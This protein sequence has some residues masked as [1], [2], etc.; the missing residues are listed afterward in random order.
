MPPPTPECKAAH[1]GSEAGSGLHD[2]ELT[3]F[4]KDKHWELGQPTDDATRRRCNERIEIG[5]FEGL[6]IV[7]VCHEK[8][9]CG[10]KGTLSYIQ[11]R[12]VVELLK[13]RRPGR[14]RNSQNQW[15]NGMEGGWQGW[16]P[17]RVGQGQQIV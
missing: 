13:I 7:P 6:N 9:T 5:A 10:H 16:H 8:G 17:G 4:G 14:G 11:R 1:C 15:P 2:E 3:P 12:I